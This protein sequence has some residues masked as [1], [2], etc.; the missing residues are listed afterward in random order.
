M[1]RILT[2]IIA[3]VI[4][5]FAASSVFAAQQDQQMNGMNMKKNTGKNMKKKGANVKKKRMSMKKK[6]TNTK[7][8]PVKK[9]TDMGDMKM[10]DME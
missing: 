9:K 4:A 8:K 2:L 10:K 1:K 7:K 6:S 5:A 3:G